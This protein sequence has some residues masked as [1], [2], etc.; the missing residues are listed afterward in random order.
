VQKNVLRIGF[1]SSTEN[2]AFFKRIFQKIEVAPLA[3]KN[4]NPSSQ[5][6][7]NSFRHS[8]LPLLMRP[9]LWYWRREPEHHRNPVPQLIE[10]TAMSISSKHNLKTPP[11]TQTMRRKDKPL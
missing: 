3:V 5:M 10:A 7:K 6:R 1:D 8:P 4:R 2:R 9:I 11:Q